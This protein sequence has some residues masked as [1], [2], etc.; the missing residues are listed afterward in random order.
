[1]KFSR[2]NKFTSL[3]LLIALVSLSIIT[4]VNAQSA[5]YPVNYETKYTVWGGY[6]AK[7]MQF[8][9]KTRNSQT[10]ILRIG[11]QK[12][13]KDLK[14]D[15]SLWY[16][17]GIIPYLHFDYPKRDANDRRTSNSG[18]GISPAGFLIKKTT[19]K[20]FTPFAQTTGGIIFM[21]DFFPTDEA[22]RLN[23]TFDIILGNIFQITPYSD[24]SLGYKF[25]HISNAQTGNQNP[26]LDS[27][28]IFL[29]LSIH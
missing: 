4:N 14:K 1:M 27:N 16:T 2:F 6:S 17:A 28:F 10:Q 19:S 24:I 21:D 23:F 3:S 22:R 8:L 12:H 7:S 26:G 9:G 20:W 18:F 29:K 11:F 13:L 5:T 25:H 15:L